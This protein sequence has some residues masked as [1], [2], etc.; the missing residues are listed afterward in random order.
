MSCDPIRAKISGYLDDELGV[1]DAEAVRAHLPTCSECRAQLEGLRALKHAIARLPSTEEPPGAIRAHV[2]AMRFAQPQPRYR[3]LIATTAAT[4][5]LLLAFYLGRSQQPARQLA[6]DLVAD[7][8]HSVPEVRPAE[9]TS[10]DPRVIAAF[11]AGHLPFEPV[12][13]R[14]PRANLIGGRLCKLDGRRV[15][16]LFYDHAGQTLSLFVTDRQQADDGCESARG[17]SV[18]GHRQGDLT[19]FLVGAL[20]QAELRS[21]LA[22]GSF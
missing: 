13:P 1:A 16:L 2:E 22:D 11:F 5:I 17:H 4:A 21:L 18:C 7:H 3:W 14:L 9:V 20:P 15:Q 10:Q 8:L 19:L 6:D 12:V